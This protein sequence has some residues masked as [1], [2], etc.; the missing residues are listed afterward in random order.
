MSQII[1]YLKY[2]CKNN[3]NFNM[4]LIMKSYLK[5]NFLKIKLIKTII[6]VA[7]KWTNLG[8]ASQSLH[9]SYAFCGCHEKMNLR[10]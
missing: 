9:T 3:R 2:Y 4:L 1:I 7:T 8:I 10:A 6:T 5:I